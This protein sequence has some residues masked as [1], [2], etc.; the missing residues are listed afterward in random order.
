MP[1]AAAADKVT[2][3]VNDIA[4]KLVQQ[5]PLDKKIALKSRS[6]E[7][8]GL[9]EEF[10]RQLLNDVETALFRS[11]D[12]KMQI[13]NRTNT[14]L[15]WEETIEFGNK[16]FD[17]IYGLVFVKKINPADNL[18][19]ETKKQNLNANIEASFNQSMENLLKNKLGADIEYQLFLKN[20]DNLFL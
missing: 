5:L 14:E 15:V 17:D 20:I 10:L 3:V 1:F 19:N 8:T 18:I 4:A 12:F 9:P 11:S 6:P 7:E 16:D 2:V 13:L